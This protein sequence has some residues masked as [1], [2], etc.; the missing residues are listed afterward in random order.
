MRAHE[1]KQVVHPRE[2]DGVNAA[3]SPSLV[4][5]HLDSRRKETLDIDYL[6]QRIPE[7]L[8][9]QRLF[10]RQHLIEEW[11]CLPHVHRERK[12]VNV[13]KAVALFA[14]A[15]AQP[16]ELLV[17]SRLPLRLIAQ[18]E[19]RDLVAQALHLLKAL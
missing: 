18:D 15:A 4:N 13:G 14:Q 11:R 6:A 19:E 12:H 3:L 10:H 8:R 9:R 7:S 16:R 17:D 2:Q 1:R 5:S